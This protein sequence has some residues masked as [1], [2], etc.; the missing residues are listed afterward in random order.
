MRPVEED[1]VIVLGEFGGLGMPI[2]GHTWQDE[3]NWGYVSYDTQEKLTDAYVDLLTQ[4]RPLIGQGLSAAVYTQT[5]DVESE[6]NGLMTYDRERVKMDVERIAAAARRLYGPPPMVIT[7]LPTS[8]RRKQDWRY[9]TTEPQ[10]EWM[11]PG[12]DDTSWPSGEG[13]FGTA[14]TPGAVIGTTW[15]GPAIWLRRTFN[16]ENFRP[17]G[18]QLALRIHHDEDA[19]IYLNGRRIS[20]RRGFVSSYQIVPLDDEAVASL[21]PG[22]NTLAAHCRQTRGGQFI[23]VGLVLVNEPA[24]GQTSVPAPDGRN[25][26][27]R[28][29]LAAEHSRPTRVA[30]G[31]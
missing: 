31:R 26:G 30:V 17:N 24:D 12:F 10:G 6:V 15:N 23:D 3:K 20:R 13:G 2:R 4:M 1:R 18:G 9:T 16:I 25:L 14:G 27:A 5:S 21:K 19:E 28:R 8:E 7:L 29:S 11:K 22:R